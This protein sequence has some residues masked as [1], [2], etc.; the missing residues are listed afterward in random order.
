[1]ATANEAVPATSMERR[2]WRGVSLKNTM[3]PVA[4]AMPTGT[5]IQ[6]IQAHDTD[7]MMRP[8]SSGPTTAATAQ[9]LAR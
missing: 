4:A 3:K 2:S 9:T 6:K 8:P 5:F 1:M 7:R